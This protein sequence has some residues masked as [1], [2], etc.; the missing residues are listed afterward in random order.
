MGW[1]RGWAGPGPSPKQA[2]FVLMVSFLNVCFLLFCFFLPV[3]ICSCYVCFM[4]PP[5]LLVF[6]PLFLLLFVV[7]LFFGP[8]FFAD[9][10][11]A[12]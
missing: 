5:L 10:R 12:A 1:G 9:W 11:R 3:S 7:M 6:T 2:L 8:L 4:F